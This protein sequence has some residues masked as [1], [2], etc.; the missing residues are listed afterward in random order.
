M[1][2]LIALLFLLSACSFNQPIGNKAVPEPAQAVDLQKYLGLWYEVA[3]FDN[4][5]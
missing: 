1:K 2:K 3:R 4:Q 5:F